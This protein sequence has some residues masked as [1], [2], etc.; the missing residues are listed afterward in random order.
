MGSRLEAI[1]E[2]SKALSIILREGDVYS[3]LVVISKVLSIWE[4]AVKKT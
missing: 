4:D 1:N 3:T 2:V